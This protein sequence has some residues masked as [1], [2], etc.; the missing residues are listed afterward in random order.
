MAPQLSIMEGRG[1][2]MVFVT[3]YVD[4]VVAGQWTDPSFK[5]GEG[6][7]GREKKKKKERLS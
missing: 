4:Q 7:E 3:G 5:P 2:L 1:C 6:V